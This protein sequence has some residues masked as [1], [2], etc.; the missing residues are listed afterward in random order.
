[1][2]TSQSLT[3]SLSVGSAVVR[4]PMHAFASLKS[5]KAKVKPALGKLADAA[6]TVLDIQDPISAHETERQAQAARVAEITGDIL[7]RASQSPEAERVFAEEVGLVQSV[8]ERIGDFLANQQQSTKAPSIN[9]M[10]TDDNKIRDEITAHDKHLTDAMSRLNTNLIMKMTL[11]MHIG[12]SEPSDSLTASSVKGNE[13]TALPAPPSVR[14]PPKHHIFHGREDVAALIEDALMRDEGSRF[15]ILGTGDIGKTSTA[16]FLL[17][18]PEIEFKFG[19]ERIFISCETIK[20]AE[21][22]V[23]S[24]AAACR[25]TA[26]LA[27][28]D[29]LGTLVNSL[30]TR[31]I[32]MLLALDNFETAWDSREQGEVED[33]LMHL[34]DVENFSFMVTIRGTQRPGGVKWTKPVLPTWRP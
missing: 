7:R 25:V 11:S 14:L 18:D 34:D 20:S 10:V 13:A 12:S 6:I 9:R 26:A 3:P 31:K 5:M 15:A 2:A 22:L 4:L 8:I 1:M 29:R 27:G 24:L 16:A 32:P 17:H 28:G 33:V 30:R 21:D 19:A 23:T